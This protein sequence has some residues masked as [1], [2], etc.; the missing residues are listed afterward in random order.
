MDAAE[1][2]TW[3]LLRA[4]AIV[5]LDSGLAAKC[6]TSEI[7]FRNNVRSVSLI[8]QQMAIGQN[9]NRTPSEHPNPH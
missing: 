4:Q 3:R 9:P 8:K 6:A 7:Y 5:E 1:Q 2:R